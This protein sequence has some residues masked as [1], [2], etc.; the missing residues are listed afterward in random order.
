MRVSNSL[1]SD[2]PSNFGDNFLIQKLRGAFSQSELY[3][4]I[5]NVLEY[6]WKIIIH[7]LPYF[8]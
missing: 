2:M 6:V 5:H 3:V 8:R 7:F 1:S 4:N